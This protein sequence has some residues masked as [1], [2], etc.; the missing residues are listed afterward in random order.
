[1]SFLTDF[2][3]SAVQS[4]QILL[5]NAG[6]SPRDLDSFSSSS[7]PSPSPSSPSPLPSPSSLPGTLPKICPASLSTRNTC[8]AVAGAHYTPPPARPFTAE[9]H[10]Q[11]RHRVTRKTSAHAIVEHPIGAIVEYPQTGRHA[12]ESIA[13]IFHI[14]PSTFTSTLRPKSSFQYSLGDGHGGQIIGKCLMLR[15]AGGQP[16]SCAKLRTS[17]KGLKICSGRQHN[18]SAHHFTNVSEVLAHHP[19]A[20]RPRGPAGTA[21]QELFEKTLAFFVALCLRGCSPHSPTDGHNN[22]STAN[23]DIVEDIKKKCNGRLV[24]HFDAYN[25]PFIR[26][27]LHSRIARSH[28][29]IRNLQESDTCYLQALLDDDR[30]IITKCEQ[31]AMSRGYGP[32]MPCSFVTGPS[33]QKQVC[34]HWHRQADGT[35]KQGVLRKWGHNCVASFDI[36]VPEDLFACPRI[37]VLCTNPHSH[38]PPLPVKTPPPLID[39]FHGLVSLMK[40]KLADATPRRIYLDTAFVEG[41]HQVLDWQFPDGRDA[42]LQDLHPSLANLDHVRRLINLTRSTKYPSGTGFEGACRLANEHASLPL[43]QR[44]VRCAETH[45]IDHG[46]E[47]KLVVCMTSR[48]SSHLVQAKHLS[49]DTSFKR[50][51][52]WQEFEIES[53]DSEHCRSVVSARAFTTSQSAKAHLILFQRIFDIASADTGHSFSFQHIHGF[54]CEIVIADSHKGQGLG[55]G[56]YCVQLSRSIS[57]PCVHEPHRRVCDLSPYDHLRRFYR[58]CV[59]HFKRN[60]HALRTHVSDEVYSA[61]LSLATCEEHPD[62]QRTF[63]TI[64]CGGPKA[65]AWLKDKLEG[66]KFAL[67]ALYQPMSLIPLALWKASPSTTNG[68]EQAHRNAYREGVHLTLLAG[69]MKGMKFDQG[70]TSSMN[71]HATFGIST[72]DQEATQVYRATRCIVRQSTSF[73]LNIEYN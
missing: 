52:G 60:V 66:T 2:Q 9:D 51:Q 35:L 49:V 27:S 13:H 31:L 43:E 44:Y 40:W 8:L 59:A 11:G 73:I 12:N 50:A 72:R 10:M 36:Y 15:D 5:E 45:V 6:L 24:M 29:F 61:M 42:M 53:W 41:L 20:L 34:P 48:M 55:L 26:C 37:L 23:T 28:L 1:M 18:I 71:V 63:N 16:V 54:G 3:R 4:A 39:V 14:D 17:C 70:A 33:S 30:H 7:S 65:A 67:P 68:N 32:L 21:D 38:P 47:F 58:L 64:R 56:M 19:S 69:I 62:I 57:T 46:V 25:Q 22:N